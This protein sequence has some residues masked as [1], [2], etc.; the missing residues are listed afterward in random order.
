MAKYIFTPGGEHNINPKFFTLGS[1]WADIGAVEQEKVKEKISFK[2][3]EKPD[4]VWATLGWRS[5]HP[6]NPQGEIAFSESG[7]HASE[8]PVTLKEIGAIWDFNPLS[9]EEGFVKERYIN[10]DRV[11]FNLPDVSYKANELP[12]LRL[13]LFLGKDEGAVVYYQHS[14]A[15]KYL[16]SDPDTEAEIE[17]I[18]PQ[19]TT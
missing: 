5:D 1:K 8:S 7:N 16:D 11:I 9:G 18:L 10:F 19:P 15:D 13:T 12:E 17:Y 4:K 14:A 6:F 3:E 2:T